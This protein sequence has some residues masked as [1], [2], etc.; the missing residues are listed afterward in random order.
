MPQDPP[1]IDQVAMQ[2][3]SSPSHDAS[4]DQGQDQ[5]STSHVEVIPIMIIKA[6]IL[7]NVG[8]QMIK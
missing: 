5:P 1:I 8:T 7:V 4:H 3:P 2:E 6:N